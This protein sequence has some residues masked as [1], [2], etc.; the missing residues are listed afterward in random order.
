MHLGNFSLSHARPPTQL[1]H[2]ADALRWLWDGNECRSRM[3]AWGH[4]MLRFVPTANAC[5]E[6]IAV[7]VP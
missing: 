4:G 5:G 1:H 3:G 2:S 6:I 7:D